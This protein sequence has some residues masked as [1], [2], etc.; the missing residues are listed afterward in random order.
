M[1]IIIL[2]TSAKSLCILTGCHVLF[3]CFVWICWKFVKQSVGVTLY[4]CV[5]EQV[6]KHL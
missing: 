6:G 1:G 3:F 5:S 2:G 4:G